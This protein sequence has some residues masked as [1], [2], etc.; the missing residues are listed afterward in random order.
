MFIRITRFAK[1]AFILFCVYF[2]FFCVANSIYSSLNAPAPVLAIQKIEPSSSASTKPQAELN[3]SATAIPAS[4]SA[5]AAPSN[6]FQGPTCGCDEHGKTCFDSKLGE[7]LVCSHGVVMT[8]AEQHLYD[9]MI[10]RNVCRPRGMPA[11]KIC[12]TG[13]S[14]PSQNLKE[15]QACLDKGWIS[16]CHCGK[17]V[18]FSTPEIR[19]KLEDDEACDKLYPNPNES[20]TIFL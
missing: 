9:S 16:L 7:N 18:D 20:C 1:Q 8:T 17:I 15:G 19:M 10:Y 13:E 6:C 2:F 14:C 11:L 5:S 12:K 3:L 4:P